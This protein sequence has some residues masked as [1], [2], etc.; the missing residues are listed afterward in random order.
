[1]CGANKRFLLYLLLALLFV[2]VAG[3]LRA[4]EP[5][6]AAYMPMYLI[7]EAE[8]R[9]I[10]EYRNESE[11]EKQIWLSQV[12]ALKTQALN[13]QQE[14]KALNSQLAAQQEQNRELQRSFNE[15]EAG[16]LIL[17][18]SK[19]GEIADLKQVIA[20]TALEAEARK[21]IARSRLILIIALAG[22]WVVFIAFKACRFFK[23]V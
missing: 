19:N 13:L 22:A 4:G 10:E 1:M 12:Q 15:Y 7:S 11:A 3:A 18:S 23:I 14:S 17:I 20:E 9:S 16:Q 2:S 6:P 21:G 8:L 5:E